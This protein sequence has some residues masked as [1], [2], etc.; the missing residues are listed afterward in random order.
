MISMTLPLAPSTNHL[1][2]NRRGGGRA[3]A[4]KYLAWRAE[5]GTE[6]MAQRPS[7]GSVRTVEGNYCLVI[8]IPADARLDLDNVV[9][10]TSDLLVS[11]GI[12]ED[13]SR[14]DIIILR[15]GRELAGTKRMR[16]T[17]SGA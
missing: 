12:V 9:K 4:P 5:A 13:D 11:M 7:W 16:V 3:L 15:R 1:F 14:A 8:G 2:I 10:A 6:I 17:V